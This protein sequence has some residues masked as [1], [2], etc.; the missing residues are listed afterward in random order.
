MVGHCKFCVTLIGGFLLFREPIAAN[1]LLGILSTLSGIAAYTYLK[2]REQ[3]RQER[4]TSF[5]SAQKV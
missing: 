5:K 1:Q 3:A 2:L 4:E